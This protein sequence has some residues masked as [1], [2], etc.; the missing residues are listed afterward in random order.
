MVVGD[1]LEKLADTNDLRREFLGSDEFKQKNPGFHCVSLSG[2]EP[3][4]P[5]EDTADLEELLSHIQKVW[6]DPG[7]KEPYW[8]VLVSEQFKSSS[9]KDTR[10]AFYESGRNNVLTVFKTLQRNKIDYASFKTC[11]E[12]G[13]VELVA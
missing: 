11:L 6:E 10:N 12:Y 5:I 7:Q 3:P 8:S 13:C 2:N 9:I 1:K 4:M